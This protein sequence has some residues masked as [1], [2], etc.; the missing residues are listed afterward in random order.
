MPISLQPLSLL[1]WRRLLTFS[2]LLGRSL[3]LVQSQTFVFAFRERGKREWIFHATPTRI[4]DRPRDFECNA[5]LYAF[6]RHWQQ[7]LPG[8]ER[9]RVP[10]PPR[11]HRW[12]QG[13]VHRSAFRWQPEDHAEPVERDRWAR[14]LQQGA[15]MQNILRADNLVIQNDTSILQC[16]ANWSQ[17]FILFAIH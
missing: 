3:E 2:F 9:L 10:G 5:A 17:F 11:H 4:S 6:S 1:H 13:R 15:L 14:W 8:Q 12:R 16:H 7:W